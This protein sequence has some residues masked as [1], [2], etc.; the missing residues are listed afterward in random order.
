[1][2]PQSES[3]YWVG[4]DLGGTKMMAAV[5][6][7]DFAILASERRKTKGTKGF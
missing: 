6:D 1:M 4:F 5:L 3:R 7:K 2:A